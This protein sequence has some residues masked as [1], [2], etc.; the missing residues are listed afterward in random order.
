MDRSVTALN[1]SLAAARD[2]AEVLMIDADRKARALSGKVHCA[3]NS[4]PS[5]LAW[6]SIDSKAA[7][8]IKTANG[9]S[10]LPAAAGNGAKATEAI[11]KSLA[12]VRATGGYDLVILDGPVLPWEADDRKLLETVDGIV[13]VL[14]LS[15]DINEAMEDIITSLGIAQR[16]L[17][18]VILNELN[19]P[20]QRGKQ[21]A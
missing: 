16:K 20:V 21:Y 7:R 6:L 12:Q 5:R 9:I 10:I 3:G 1:F 13:A 17:A 18:G 4:E 8:A 14:P 15:L 19:A 11:G 2:G